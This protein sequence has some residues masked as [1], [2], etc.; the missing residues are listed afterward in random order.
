MTPAIADAEVRDYLDAVRARLSDLDPEEREHLLSDTEASL[1]EAAED[2]VELPLEVRLGT[3][4]RFARELRAAA[5]LPEVPVRDA[6][7]GLLVRLAA[8]RR[9]VAARGIARELAPVWWVAR[10]FAGLTVLAQLFGDD[11]SVR[12]PVITSVLG[13]PLGWFLLLGAIAGSVALGRRERGAARRWPLVMNLAFAVAAGWVVVTM[14]GNAGAIG[15]RVVYVGSSS[16]V[17]QSGLAWDGRP[18]GN[19]YPYDRQGRLLQDVRLYDDTGTPLEIRRGES[20]PRRVVLD[21]SGKRLFNA[22]PIRYFDRGTRRVSRPQAGALSK[23]PRP[24][25]TPPVRTGR[26]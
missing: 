22:F 9:V 24:I 4:E 6:R 20:R 5:G 11:W 14:A 19:V 8:H 16:P 12:Y 21:R 18:I 7:P 15:M 23:P 25:V 2:E 3:P 26:R 10:A 17:K 13:K 1:L